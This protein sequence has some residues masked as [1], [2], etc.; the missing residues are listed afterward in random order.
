TQV[1]NGSLTS[2]N[3]TDLEDIADALKLPI[4][5]VKSVLIFRITDHFGQYPRLKED[6]LF[7][8]L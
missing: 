7:I 1:F 2:K 3:K 6:P 8:G 5:G 4:D